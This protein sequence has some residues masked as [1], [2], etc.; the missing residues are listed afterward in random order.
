MK[1]L[2][3][4]LLT[5]CLFIQHLIAQQITWQGMSSPSNSW[6]SEI[7]EGP[8]S[9]LFVNSDGIY[10]LINN[11]T[12]WRKINVSLTDTIIGD[13]AISAQGDIFLFA[14]DQPHSREWRLYRSADKGLSWNQLTNGLIQMTQG[15]IT[16]DNKG[17]IILAMTPE[18]F[19]GNR[20]YKSFDNG[21]SWVQTSGQLSSNTNSIVINSNNH[22]FAGTGSAGIFV[23]TNL[24]DIWTPINK[25]LTNLT[26]SEIAIS[27]AGYIF[28]ST[29]PDS[30]Y[31]LEDNDTLWTKI[32][33]G[34]A[35]DIEFDQK[36]NVYIGTEKGIKCS[37]DNGNNWTSVGLDSLK[38]TCLKYISTGYLIAGTNNGNLFKSEQLITTI[39]KEE[40]LVPIK[41]ALQQNYPNPFNPS[42]NI[43]FTLPSQTL[44]SLKVFDLMGREVASIVS[45][46]MSAGNHSKQWN[47]VNMSS[48]IY[49]Y[50]LT[51]GSFTET[52]KLVLIR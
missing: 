38:I 16:F 36:G 34:F 44:V 30:I 47:A 50:R 37:R 15:K 10:R 19:S 24:G 25:G 46:E 21:D 23:S 7:A 5:H 20:F 1:Q 12:T 6:I 41:T 17:I 31:R 35:Y 14:A 33:N 27:P 49:F 3:L 39:L 4:I 8:D 28:T 43:S 52:K 42:T 26:I 11:G 45:E 40:S 18:N 9:S 13:I 32:N 48:G 51:A 29:Y 22:L 2:F